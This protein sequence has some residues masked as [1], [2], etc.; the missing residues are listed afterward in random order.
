MITAIVWLV[1]AALPDEG[2]AA[3]RF[4]YVVAAILATIVVNR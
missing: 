4:L 2:K 3:N 1:A